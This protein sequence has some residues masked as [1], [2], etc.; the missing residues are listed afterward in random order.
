MPA[1]IV[2]RMR[3]LRAS[4]RVT[5]PVASPVTQTDPRPIA[6]PS[7][8]GLDGRDA[9][10]FSCCRI[11]AGDAAIVRVRD[12]HVVLA[13]GDAGGCVPDLDRLDARVRLRVDLRDRGVESIR[14]PH[15]APPERDT[16]RVVADRDRLNHHA[17][18]GVDARHGVRID[19]RHPDRSRP[20]RDGTRGR[21]SGD[22]D[23]C[24]VAPALGVEHRHRVAVDRCDVRGA[25]IGECEPG[26]RCDARDCRRGD[27]GEDRP[28]GRR[29]PAP[30]GPVRR[31]ARSG[32][33]Q[34]ELESRVV[35]QDR[36]LE[37]AQLAA[38]LD[39]CVLD[40]ERPHFPEVLEGVGLPPGTVEREHELCAR[41]FSQ[42]FV[43]HVSLERGDQVPVQAQR[44][45]AVDALLLDQEA[46]LVEA[47]G[48]D[49]RLAL[50]LR[51]GQGIAPPEIE[52]AVICTQRVRMLAGARGG[53]RSRRQSGEAA[54]VELVVAAHGEVAGDARRNPRGVAEGLSKPRDVLVDHVLRA[55]RRRLAPDAV[56]QALDRY[57]VARV[58]EKNAEQRA[59]APPECDDVFVHLDL[60][61]TQ[62]P[63][64]RRSRR[65]PGS[66]AGGSGVHPVPPA[67][68]P[69]SRP[70]I[71][72]RSAHGAARSERGAALHTLGR[73]ALAV[74]TRGA[75]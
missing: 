37:P 14:D 40:E 47:R 56:D 11:D 53:A 69:A 22:G 73:T 6:T 13:G 50:E 59:L 60:E 51:S 5:M 35:L 67:R 17:C 64:D 43:A 61:R 16:R 44:E 30:L 68:R 28:P 12:P 75:A 15:E 70:R 74:R 31:L 39:S 26:R 45:R 23:R 46:L 8:P 2:P 3:P 4:S 71:P 24:G 19:V 49:T 52:R 25:A 65:G 55:R 27:G 42:G 41:A 58:E 34:L 1:R 7:A 32:R 33:R 62:N 66:H 10:R 9:T 21:P 18:H 54:H 38:G 57:D 48:V 63:E 20:R 36:P 29:S 72:S